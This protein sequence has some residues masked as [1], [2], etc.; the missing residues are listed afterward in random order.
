MCGKLYIFA[1]AAY[2]PMLDEDRLHE[3]ENLF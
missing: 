1:K 3:K 2:V